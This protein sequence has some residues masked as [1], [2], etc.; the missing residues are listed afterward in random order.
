MLDFSYVNKIEEG[1]EIVANGNPD[2]E[3]FLKNVK[4]QY[5]KYIADSYFIRV[6]IDISKFNQSQILKIIQKCNNEIFNF[7]IIMKSYDFCIIKDADLIDFIEGE[8]FFD[9]YILRLKLKNFIKIKNFSY[10]NLKFKI[11]DLINEIE[12]YNENA[13]KENKTLIAKEKVNEIKEYL[14]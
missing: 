9:V 1:I 11:K 4:K 2:I 3:T 14:I 12:N 13:I 8:K 10:N 6:L 7:L 5:S